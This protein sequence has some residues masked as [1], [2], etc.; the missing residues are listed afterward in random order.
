L[1][2]FA[3][4]LLA[5]LALWMLPAVSLANVGDP[6]PETPACRRDGSARAG[7]RLP[8]V[9]RTQSLRLSHALGERRIVAFYGSPLGPGLGVLGNSLPK[10]MLAQ[11]RA[12]ADAYQQIDPEAV[13]IPAFHMVTTVADAYPDEDE[14][15][16]HR[17]SHDVIREWIDWAAEEKVWVILDIQPGRGDPLAEFDLIEPFLHE[18]HVHLA[19]DPEFIVD[20]DGVPGQNLGRIDGATINEFQARLDEIAR[21]I[22]VTKVLIVHQFD[23][24]MIADKDAIENVWT[25]ELVWDADGFGSPGAKIADYQQY[26]GEAGFE[27]GGFKLFY[28][29]DDPLMTPAQVLGLEPGPS[30]II[31]Q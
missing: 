5:A 11:L 20:G 29:E 27:K 16:N 4:P 19:V 13:V 7:C 17:L 12:Q 28:R 15:Y 21:S 24:R 26:R 8:W 14:D 10:T 31:Y 9:E 3:L 22:G 2:R 25:V 30:I 1:I 23:D 6:E 18:T